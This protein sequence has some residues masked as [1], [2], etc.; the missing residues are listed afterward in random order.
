VFLKAIEP[1]VFAIV[2]QS[3]EG[4]KSLLLEIDGFIRSL[5]P[6]WLMNCALRDPPY[7]PVCIFHTSLAVTIWHIAS[8]HFERGAVFEC[9]PH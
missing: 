9:T 1:K 7:V 6:V 5:R 8:F 2:R 4:Q 3:N